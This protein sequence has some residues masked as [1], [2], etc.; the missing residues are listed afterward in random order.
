MSE[1]WKKIE[2]Y[3]GY[4]VSSFGNVWS[5]KLKRIIIAPKDK[6][7]YS[8][9]GLWKQQ[10]KKHHFV[11]RLVAEAFIPNPDNK[12]VVNHINGVKGDNRSENLEWNTVLEN[13]QHSRSVLK[14]VIPKG[15]HTKPLTLVKDSEELTFEKTRDAYKFLNCSGQ[16]F[17]KLKD[18]K[19]V[20]GWSIKNI[21][22]E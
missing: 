17:K 14:K 7:G 3:P 21:P 6:D 11:H 12:P 18:G 2:E 16:Q 1:A 15:I 19:S 9:I 5:N 4:L 10:K 8:R 20:K 22:V 13:E